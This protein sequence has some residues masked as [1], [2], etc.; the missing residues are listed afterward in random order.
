VD[1]PPQSPGPV[2]PEPQPQPSQQQYSQP[3][4]APPVSPDGKFWWNGYQWIPLQ[5][6]T[7]PAIFLVGGCVAVLIVIVL[8]A[9]LGAANIH[10][11]V[12]VDN[13]QILSDIRN[14]L[15]N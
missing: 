15:N 3:F 9:A 6:Q 13:N 8:L 1:T 2:Q 10:G 4:Y 14:N 12:Y 5:R 7:N 11:A